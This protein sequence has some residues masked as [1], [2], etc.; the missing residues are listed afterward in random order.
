MKTDNAP[1]LIQAIKELGWIPEPSIAKRWPH[2][3]IH[4]RRHRI[5]LCVCRSAMQQ[6]GF[7]IKCWNWVCM[8][9]CV[10]INFVRLAP[11]LP[12]E[13]S[14]V[15][16]SRPTFEE[17]HSRTSW[18]V[19]HDGKLFTGPEQL[20]GRLV[21]YKNMSDDK[22][23]MH[24]NLSPGFFLGWEIKS[25]L[26]YSEM[27]LIGDYERFKAGDFGLDRIKT[28]P[29]KELFFDDEVIFLFKNVRDHNLRNMSNATLPDDVENLNADLPLGVPQPDVDP[30]TPD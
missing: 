19:W 20:F 3:T 22:H 28:V 8:Y 1:A 24:P 21:W 15:G 30:A 10:A 5:F 26:R 18:E 14:S 6:S 4:E 23:K 9:A 17:K 29:D 27:C 16:E 2:N 13:L 11:K 7:P 25:G 12:N